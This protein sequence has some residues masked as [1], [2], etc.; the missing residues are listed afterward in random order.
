MKEDYEVKVWKICALAGCMVLAAALRVHPGFAA[1]GIPV[2]PR[3]FR[4]RPSKRR[5]GTEQRVKRK[6]RR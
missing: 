2:A 3:L 1:D 4:E 5:P 6:K